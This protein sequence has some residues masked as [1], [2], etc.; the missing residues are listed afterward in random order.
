M[1][2]KKPDPPTFFKEVECEI[3]TMAEEENSND[4]N[5]KFTNL[6]EKHDYIISAMNKVISSVSHQKQQYEDLVYELMA[7]Y[8]MAGIS[9][10]HKWEVADTSSSKVKVPISGPVSSR[11]ILTFTEQ[12]IM[13]RTLR[14][15]PPR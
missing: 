8:Y 2:S 14:G 3:P 11:R 15:L 10:R 13:E 1:A 7:P 5:S 12:E 6:M 4:P 9:L